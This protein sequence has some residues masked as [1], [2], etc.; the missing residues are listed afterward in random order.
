VT[1]ERFRG[2]PA[3]FYEILQERPFA[4]QVVQRLTNELEAGEILA[5][6]ETRVHTHSYRK[7]LSKSYALSPYLLGSALEALA[8][9]RVVGKSPTGRNYRLPA[10][11]RWC[12]S[13]GDLVRR[14]AYGAF[15]EHARALLYSGGR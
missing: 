7:T 5:F 15:Y 6:A 10:T 1:P 9:G 4:G 12:A 2:S 11:G 14:L 3:G 8:S 13:S